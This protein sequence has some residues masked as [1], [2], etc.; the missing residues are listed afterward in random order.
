MEGIKR[1][2]CNCASWD[3]QAFNEK[4]GLKDEVRKKGGRRTLVREIS[5]K[6]VPE[7]LVKLL[8]EE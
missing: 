5:P 8:P 2:S 6:L 1:G 4:V 3:L 7:I